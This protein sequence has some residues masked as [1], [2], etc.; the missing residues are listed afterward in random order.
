ML[1]C[2]VHEHM[3]CFAEHLLLQS[4]CGRSHVFT[5]SIACILHQSAQH[6]YLTAWLYV[7]SSSFTGVACKPEIAYVQERCYIDE[8]TLLHV[9]QFPVYH[10]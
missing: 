2:D 3:T 9:V 6:E 4:S 1:L 5:A 7:C 10:I 8:T